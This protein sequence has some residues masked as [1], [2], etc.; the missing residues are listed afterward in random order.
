MIRILTTLLLILLIVFSRNV[1]T[2]RE[3]QIKSSSY[4][5]PKSNVHTL[6]SIDEDIETDSDVIEIQNHSHYSRVLSNKEKLVVLD[7]YSHTCAPCKM[8]APYIEKFAAAYTKSKFT[9]GK[10][11]CDNL[12]EITGENGVTGMPTIVFFKNGHE[13]S[14]VVGVDVKAIR[15]ILDKHA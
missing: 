6:N 5:K 7:F 2:N 1:Q 8:L 10:V 11:N 12:P 13:V 9:F 4:K 14:R 3:T 15:N